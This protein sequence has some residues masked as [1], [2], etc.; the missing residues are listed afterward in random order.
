MI[1]GQVGDIAFEGREPNAEVLEYIHKR[2]TAALIKAPVLSPAILYDV[3]DKESSALDRYGECIGLVFQIIDD[4]LD[5]M[6]DPNKVGKTLGKDK[7]AGKQTFTH[8]YGIEES[9][10]IAKEKTE[11][12]AAALHIFGSRAD[13]LIQL[14]EYMLTR[15]K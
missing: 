4:I 10:R 3:S 12:A 1:A 5:E 11:Q 6:G 8:I 2:K 7:Q 9:R 15:D 14:A 13:R